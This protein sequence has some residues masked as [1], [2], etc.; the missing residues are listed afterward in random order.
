MIIFPIWQF[1]MFSIVTWSLVGLMQ[2]ANTGVDV[3]LINANHQLYLGMQDHL[4]RLIV[5]L[6]GHYEVFV[7]CIARRLQPFW[8]IINFHCDYKPHNWVSWRFNRGLNFVLYYLFHSIFC[9]DSSN[10]KCTFQLTRTAKVTIA[11]ETSQT[12]TGIISVSIGTICILMTET[13]SF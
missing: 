12:F 3:K 10:F 9:C 5:Y 6:L 1:S 7:H 4:H 8:T 11:N 2:H 13:W